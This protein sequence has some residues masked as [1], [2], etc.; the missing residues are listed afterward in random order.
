MIITLLHLRLR[1]FQDCIIY[2]YIHFEALHFLLAKGV[3]DTRSLY[4]RAWLV[5]V[6]DIKRCEWHARAMCAEH[7]R[8]HTKRHEPTRT[9]LHCA[10]LRQSS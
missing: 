5:A 10:G 1:Y 4:A 9:G 2:I 7:A 3:L 8:T 6:R